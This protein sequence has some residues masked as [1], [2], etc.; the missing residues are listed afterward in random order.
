MVTDVGT[1]ENLPAATPSSVEPSAEAA[2]T[3][4]ARLAS[5]RPRQSTPRVLAERP[6]AI[7]NCPPARPGAVPSRRRPQLI[8][9]PGPSGCRIAAT[10]AD[11][12]LRPSSVN[13]P[14]E[15]PGLAFTVSATPAEATPSSTSAV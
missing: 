2:P 12:F 13:S 7:E 1:T 14:Q 5:K 11:L 15:A 9:R 10:A 4:P 3:G 6:P 8:G